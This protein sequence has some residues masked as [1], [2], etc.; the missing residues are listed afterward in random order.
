MA[1]P[2]LGGNGDF[3]PH[4]GIGYTV[5]G[6]LALLALIAAGLARADRSLL[7]ESAA[8]FVLYI[9]QTLLPTMKGSTPFLAALHPVN[10]V[11]LFG[12]AGWLFLQGRRM[13]PA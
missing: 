9:V 3:G 11:L 5:M 4:V 6:I 13:A 7:W 2:Q 1:L 12:L 10:A 8:L